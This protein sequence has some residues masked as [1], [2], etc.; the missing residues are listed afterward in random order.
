MMFL[1]STLLAVRLPLRRPWLTSDKPF[2]GN[3]ERDMRLCSALTGVP[4]RALVA[5]DRHRFWK[6][7]KYKGRSSELRPVVQ[8]PCL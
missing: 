3:L 5:S 1:E 7:M 8:L 6:R 4:W 2:Y